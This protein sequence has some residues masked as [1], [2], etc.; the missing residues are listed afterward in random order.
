[1]ITSRA[2]SFPILALPIPNTKAGCAL[3]D[4]FE[5]G[6]RIVTGVALSLSNLSKSGGRGGDC[7]RTAS[8]RVRDAEWKD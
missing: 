3:V 1:M 5:V 2:T 6:L 7:R 8:P 4:L